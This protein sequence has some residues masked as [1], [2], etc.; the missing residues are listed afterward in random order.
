MVTCGQGKDRRSIGP[1]TLGAGAKQR[2]GFELDSAQGLHVAF[3]STNGRA[4]GG[5]LLAVGLRR[6]C[7]CCLDLTC[8]QRS[9]SHPVNDNCRHAYAE[10]G[11]VFA[12]SQRTDDVSAARISAFGWA[13]GFQVERAGRAELLHSNVP[14]Y[15]IAGLAQ[16]LVWVALISL[17]VLG[18]RRRS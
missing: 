11:Q 3:H 16:L 13:N 14:S 6:R 12:K 7:G 10:A 18:R 8:G 2:H 9:R 15:W 1:L 5:A 17:L 4:Y